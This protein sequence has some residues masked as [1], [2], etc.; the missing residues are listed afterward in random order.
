MINRKPL[1]IFIEKISLDR[2][3]D[4]HEAIIEAG[5]EWF[6][7]GMFPKPEISFVN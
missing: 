3:K 6:A 4:V 7:N 2:F 5:K 1:N